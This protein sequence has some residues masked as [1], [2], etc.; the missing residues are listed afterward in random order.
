MP[1]DEG[2]AF[3][4]RKIWMSESGK[5]FG[6][7]RLVSL[8]T[9]LRAVLLQGPAGD[10][11]GP[12]ARACPDGER[13]L[14]FL[15]TVMDELTDR[16]LDADSLVRY[17]L[18]PEVLAPVLGTLVVVQL[19]GDDDA[20]SFEQER[21]AIDVEGWRRAF[22]LSGDRAQAFNRAMDDPQS[23]RQLLN[24]F[25]SMLYPTSHLYSVR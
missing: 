13:R 25:S 8:V 6:Q 3:D 4:A 22:G 17:G 20:S 10:G 19:L 21:S 1:G 14:S 16:G 24:G 5:N 18:L 12:V 9:A 11:D 23:L 2:H 15:R 7:W